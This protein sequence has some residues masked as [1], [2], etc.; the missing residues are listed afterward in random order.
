VFNVN[1]CFRKYEIG[2][3]GLAIVAVA[4]GVHRAHSEIGGVYPIDSKDNKN[5]PL[6]GG[7]LWD[8]LGL[9]FRFDSDQDEADYQQHDR[10]L[11]IIKR[12]PPYFRQ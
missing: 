6:S 2:V 12:S 5:P 11:P 4:V 8:C 7:F 1:K 9:S 10:R 3:L